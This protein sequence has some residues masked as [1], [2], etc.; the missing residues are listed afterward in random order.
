[1]KKESIT[2]IPT[3]NKLPLATDLASGNGLTVT[4]LGNMNE[5]PADLRQKLGDVL[6]NYTAGGGPSSSSTEKKGAQVVGSA[7]YT[8]CHRCGS[9]LHRAAE[10]PD[11]AG[12]S[13]KIE[14]SILEIM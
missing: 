8:G 9:M 4:S 11:A 2:T 12:D 7:S 5:L 13:G 10:C 1:M 14:P 6:A 3:P